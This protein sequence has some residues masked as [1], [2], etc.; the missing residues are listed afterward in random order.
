MARITAV[1]WNAFIHDARVLKEAQT[2]A[3]HGHDVTVVALHVP[4]VN[5]TKETLGTRLKVQRVT[6]SLFYKIRHDSASLKSAP[7]RL[8]TKPKDDFSRAK[9]VKSPF[10]FLARVLGRGAT[11][12]RLLSRIVRNRPDVVHA[13]DVN[14]LLTCWVASRVCKA[15]LVYDAHEISTS[16][17]G[18]A[19]LRWLVASI[20]NQLINRADACITTTDLR[21][22]FLARVYKVPMP[23]VL[24]NRPRLT[25]VDRSRRLSMDLGLPPDDL[26]V[27]YQGGLQPGR[28]LMELIQLVPNLPFCHFVFVGGGRLE[29][30]LKN[31]A[32]DLGISDRV[33][34]VPTVPLSELPSYTAGADVAV[35]ALRNT[36]FNHYSTDSNKLFEY[37]M[38]GVPQA[39]S[40]FPEIRR[41]IRKHDI[42]RLFDPEDPRSVSQVLTELLSDGDLRERLT[43]NAQNARYDLCWETEEPKLIKLYDKVLAKGILDRPTPD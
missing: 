29:D 8:R 26:I 36:C 3:K 43:K 4:G 23:M 16:R 20:E 35:Q 18:Y 31:L 15:K 24:Q 34:F 10:L 30:P 40:D 14:T 37:C 7:S 19:G 27:L 5:K 21:A 2:L 39:S 41:V 32:H 11:H 22:R 6:R 13:H 12:L 17:E 42:G 33:H 38:A 25:P 1:V 28:G 9:I